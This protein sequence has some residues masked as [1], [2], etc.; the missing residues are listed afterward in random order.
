MLSLLVHLLA[1]WSLIVCFLAGSEC[2]SRSL[3]VF[4][5]LSPSLSLSLSL[6]W[7]ARDML[8]P[9]IRTLYYG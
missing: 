1:C 4:V 3:S 2:L 7:A 5:F 9:I 6:Y 8:L